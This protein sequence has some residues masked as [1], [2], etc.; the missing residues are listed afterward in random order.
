MQV[1]V[2]Y[3]ANL[4]EHLGVSSET[5]QVEGTLR[6]L[7]TKLHSSHSQFGEFQSIL[8]NSSDVTISVNQEYVRDLNHLL[9]DQ[10]EVAF[11][12]PISGG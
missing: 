3:F 7:L 5:V 11:L 6:D 8:E 4:R 9:S 12:P 2:L 1:K 10:D